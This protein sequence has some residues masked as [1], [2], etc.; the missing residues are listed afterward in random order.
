M[1]SQLL[2]VFRILYRFFPLLD[3]YFFLL[4]KSNIC[5]SKKVLSNLSLKSFDTGEEYQSTL[6]P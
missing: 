5:F 4:E 3:C 6:N 2:M 1:C